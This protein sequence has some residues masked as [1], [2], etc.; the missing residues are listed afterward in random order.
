MQHF[1]HVAFQFRMN[2]EVF[3]K[4]LVSTK[5]L[6]TF[7]TLVWFH[8]QMNSWM[9][10]KTRRLVIGFATFS[11]I[12][13]F[14]SSRNY[15][16]FRSCFGTSDVFAT[17]FRFVCFLSKMNFWWSLKF[18]LNT[19]L[20]IFFVFVNDTTLWVNVCK[21]WCIFVEKAFPH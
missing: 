3:H 11:T 19:C 5:D 14:L 15:L 4:F 21:H 6:G 8:S 20:Y 9:L 1:P 16:V 10:F 13:M 18:V 17:F 7:F 12:I 2:Y